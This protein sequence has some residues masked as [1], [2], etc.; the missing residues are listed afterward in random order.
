[1]NMILAGLIGASVAAILI[2]FYQVMK[3]EKRIE[4]FEIELGGK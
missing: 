3:I 2:C 1:M 4:E